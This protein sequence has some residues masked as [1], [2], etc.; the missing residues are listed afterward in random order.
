MGIER[1][2]SQRCG[3][4]FMLALLA[5]GSSRLPAALKDVPSIESVLRMDKQ[6]E[7]AKKRSVRRRGGR[8]AGRRF[9]ISGSTGRIVRNAYHLGRRGG[10]IRQAGTSASTNRVEEQGAFLVYTGPVAN[11]AY[12]VADMRRERSDWFSP[13]VRGGANPER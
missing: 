7:E 8:V 13:T 1:A 4:A 9:F 5:T 11:A 6:T 12:T 2:R 10:V 3:R